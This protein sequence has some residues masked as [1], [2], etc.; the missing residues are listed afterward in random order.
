MP[1]ASQRPCL[2]LLVVERNNRTA[3]RCWWRTLPDEVTAGLRMR[4]SRILAALHHPDAHT[5]VLDPWLGETTSAIQS[6]G[7]R[8]GS[9]LDPSTLRVRDFSLREPPSILNPIG[10]APGQMTSSHSHLIACWPPVR[11]SLRPSARPDIRKPLR[12]LTRSN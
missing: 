4:N 9:R 5:P 7:R 2:G 1:E 10:W 3:A 8:S 6:A 11:R 12:P